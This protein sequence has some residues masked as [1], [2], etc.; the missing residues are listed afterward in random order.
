MFERKRTGEYKPINEDQK[1]FR[2]NKKSKITEKGQTWEVLFSRD[3]TRV[4]GER[5]VYNFRE[6]EI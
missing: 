3:K 4:H 2:K 5:M 6:S 1:H